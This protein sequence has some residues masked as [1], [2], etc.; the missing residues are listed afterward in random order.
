MFPYATLRGLRNLKHLTLRLIR[1]MADE[2]RE[3]E[4]C[5]NK[6]NLPAPLDRLAVVAPHLTRL[7]LGGNGFIQIPPATAGLT[8]LE[9][10]LLSACPLQ[11]LTSSREV[12]NLLPRLRVLDLR[13]DMYLMQEEGRE[14]HIPCV[15]WWSADSP[16]EMDARHDN[17]VKWIAG[18]RKHFPALSV[19]ESPSMFGSR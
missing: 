5:L 14:A 18:V 1:K 6:W 10:L 19:L 15:S 12:L 9:V 3:V 8:G 11:L 16:E 7:D 4:P 13:Q 17:L 2:Y